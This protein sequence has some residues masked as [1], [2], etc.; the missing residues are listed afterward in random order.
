[1][2]ELLID[3]KGSS[4]K[5]ICRDVRK[6]LLLVIRTLEGYYGD[7]EERK[8]RL[9]AK[10]DDVQRIINFLYQEGDLPL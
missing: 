7:G 8:K 5:S 4:V 1:M 2:K 10:Y 3:T 9:G 6:T